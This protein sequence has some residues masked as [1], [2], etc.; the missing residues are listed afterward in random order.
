TPGEWQ[1]LVHNPYHPLINKAI[2]GQYA[3][4]STFKMVV[5]LA[6]QEAGISPDY[7]AY[8]PGHTSL[9]SARFHCWKRGGHGRLSMVDGIKHSCDVYFY[10]IAHKIGI[11]AIAAMAR[12]L[13]LG[14][15]DGID[16]PGERAGVIPDSN[17][18]LATMGERWYPGETLVAGIGQG[19][20]TATPLQLAT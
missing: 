11:D 9:G 5:A 19:Y 18:K 13:G 10:D 1:A 20:I 16:L 15:V 8:C 12:R 14:H 4:G 2:G 7:T 17:W 3:P 6:A